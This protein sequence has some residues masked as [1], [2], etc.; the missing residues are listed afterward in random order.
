MPI[1]RRKSAALLVAVL[2]S[3]TLPGCATL[4]SGL[5][6]QGPP[7]DTPSARRLARGVHDVGSRDF[8]LVDR[9]RATAPNGEYPGTP[10][11]TLETTLWYPKQATGAL[12]LLIYSHGFMSYRRETEYLAKHLASHGFLVAAADHPLTNRRAPGGPE[13]QDVLQQP[14]DVSFLIDSVLA[15]EGE[16]RPFS[17]RVDRER[18][19]AMGLS[20]G[21]LTMT[22]AA[23]H[24]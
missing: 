3:V 6:P 1:E 22:L 8:S 20:L 11:R 23:F 12:P 17:G 7:P 4:W 19:G 15:L 16:E 13:V 24:P 18:I 9:T 10:S 21:G 5:G 2:A 14:A